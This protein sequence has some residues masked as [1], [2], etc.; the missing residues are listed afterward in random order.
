MAAKKETK[1]RGRFKEEIDSSALSYVAS[2]PFDWRL[3]KYDIEGSIAHA[4]MLAHQKIISSVEFKKIKN[5]LH[6]IL[7]EIE[8]GRFPF[9]KELQD[10]HMNIEGRLF[11]IIGDTAGKLHTA[12]SRN[13]QVALDMRLFTRASAMQSIKALQQLNA[14]VVDIAGNNINVIMPGYTHLQQAQPVLFSHH[15]LAYFQMFSRDIER[16][17]D[18]LVRINVLPL[19]SGALAGVPYPVDREFVAVKLG[20]DDVSENSIDAVSDRD[21]IIEFEA[22]ASIT[23]MHLSRLA[24]EMVIWSTR[25]FGFI[26]MGD[27]YSTSSSIMPQKKNPDVVELARGKTGRVYG[28]LMGM[29]TVMKGLPLAYNSDLQEDK[30]GF[31]DTID[32]LLS[33][34]QVMSGLVGA[35][36]INPSRMKSVMSSYILATDV[37]DYLVKKGLS[38]REAHGVVSRLVSYAAEDKKELDELDLKEYKKF[39][40]LFGQDVRNISLQKSIDS[41]MSYGGTASQQVKKSLERAREIIRSYETK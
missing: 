7:K 25:E 32:T 21:F 20:F 15:M 1:L 18:C 26:E 19:G 34:L 36:K 22:A 40:P 23:M 33:S 38:F 39:S 14:A 6:A 29:L 8:T 30:E 27:A 35:L 9:K 41:R 24:E 31:F 13:D 3:C 16:Y 17:Y 28:H 10:I 2:I 4:E 12:R 11:E 5:G 37:A